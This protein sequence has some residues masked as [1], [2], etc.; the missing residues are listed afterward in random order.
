MNNYYKD[1]FLPKII[2][3]GKWTNW[4]AV[5][6]VMV[7][8]ITVTFFFGI[9]PG[10]TQLMTALAAQI[11]VNAVWWFVEPV[12]F[13]Q[14]LGVPGTYMAFLTGNVSNL[15]LPCAAAALKATNTIIGTEKG[16]IISTIG[17]SASVFMN[18]TLLTICVVAGSHI[19]NMLPDAIVTKLTL[20]LPALFGAIFAQF[21][22]DDVKSAIC[23]M[24]LAIG[25][26][27]LYT[28]GL[29]NWFPIDPFIPAIIIPIFGTMIFTRITFNK[30][31]EV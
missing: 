26:L 21:A 19:M 12:S 30:R 1:E 14:V 15:R 31:K 17:V 23:G 9:V 18:T 2:R 25:S 6:W 20:L 4:V 22:V 5:L 7:P 28:K 13:F 10:K 16:T 3:I 11:S 8:A 27:L 29:L 24:G